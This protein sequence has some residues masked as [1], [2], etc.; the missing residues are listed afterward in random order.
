M[1]LRQSVAFAVLLIGVGTLSGCAQRWQ[2]PGGT[3]A[4]FEMMKA[5]CL[6]IAMQKYPPLLRPE[7]V[8]PERYDPVVTNCHPAGR[9]MICTTA[10]GGY[11]PPLVATVDD[12]E[13]VRDQ[14]VRACYFEHGWSPVRD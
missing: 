5:A 8:T 10:G 13:G 2:K 9:S 3:E 7:I 6:D 11:H 14:M 12:N 4:E 1:K